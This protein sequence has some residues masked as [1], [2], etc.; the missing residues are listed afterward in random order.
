MKSFEDYLKAFLKESTDATKTSVVKNSRGGKLG[1]IK[2]TSTD[3]V[4]NFDKK[5]ASEYN[6]R[7]KDIEMIYDELKRHT[8]TKE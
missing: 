8:T 3:V 4:F 7:L 6:Y 5:F 2:V 1:E